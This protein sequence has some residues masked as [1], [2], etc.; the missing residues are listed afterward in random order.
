MK[1]F[2]H[3][4]S[5]VSH[6]FLQNS[7]K[8]LWLIVTIKIVMTLY[9]QEILWEP[10]LILPSKCKE[11]RYKDKSPTWILNWQIC[12]TSW[13]EPQAGMTGP[14]WRLDVVA[15]LVSEN[16][17]N[18]QSHQHYYVWWHG[19][20]SEVKSPWNSA[21]TIGSDWICLKWNWILGR[22]VPLE[23]EKEHL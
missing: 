3:P 13:Q 11:A 5:T 6:I 9:I 18:V 16:R 8:T 12:C 22:D 17:E 15:R 4:W 23:V 10:H 19:F 20:V 14:T 21:G 7:T 1:H 2:D